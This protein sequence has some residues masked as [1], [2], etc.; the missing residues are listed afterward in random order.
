MERYSPG[1]IVMSN[2]NV[3]VIKY[4]GQIIEKFLGYWPKEMTYRISSQIESYN[5][6]TDSGRTLSGSEYKFLDKPG[7][8]HPK[9]HEIYIM[10]EKADGVAVSLKYPPINQ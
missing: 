2:W 10:L 1:Y 6:E 3:V 9:A 8:L 4:E 5:S 7:T